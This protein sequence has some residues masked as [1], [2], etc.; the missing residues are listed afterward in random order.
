[1]SHG[2]PT[3]PTTAH[4]RDPDQDANR[5]GWVDRWLRPG[6]RRWAAALLLLSS[7]TLTTVMV[8]DTVLPRVRSALPMDSVLSAVQL[9]PMLTHVTLLVGLAVFV[10]T[11]SAAS[12]LLGVF[13]ALTG[14]W[15]L[16]FPF[17]LG[18]PPLLDQLGPAAL[19]YGAAIAL[20]AATVTALVLPGSTA[21]RRWGPR[22]A[23][24]PS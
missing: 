6:R 3:G 19:P 20:Q 18:A 2:A 21:P 17:A 11:G 14:L 15:Q 16:V 5:A 1:M 8:D 4:G 9:A 24:T 22:T 12:R 7:G 13:A 10:C 23:S